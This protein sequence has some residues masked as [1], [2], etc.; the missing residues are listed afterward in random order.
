[1]TFACILGA[2][3]IS[4]RRFSKA[5]ELALGVERL[6]TAP[7]RNVNLTIYREPQGGTCQSLRRRALRLVTHKDAH[8]IK[9]A[10]DDRYNS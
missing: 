9:N 4:T 6:V 1:M 5:L 10:Y 3:P 8:Q 7:A 2:Y